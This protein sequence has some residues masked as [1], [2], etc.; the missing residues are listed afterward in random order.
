[1]MITNARS[2][3]SYNMRKTTSMIFPRVTGKHADDL[4]DE[5]EKKE[6]TQLEKQ[7]TKIFSFHSAIFRHSV[8]SHSAYA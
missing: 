5:W 1:M 6:G 8:A 4:Q 7:G 2:T 3:L